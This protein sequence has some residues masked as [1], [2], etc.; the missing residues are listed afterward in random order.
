M[1]WKIKENSGM[2]WVERTN[3]VQIESWEFCVPGLLEVPYNF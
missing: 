2:F 1:N 3:T